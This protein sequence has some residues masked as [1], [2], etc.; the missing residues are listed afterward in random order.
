MQRMMQ[1]IVLQ[2]DNPAAGGK[3]GSSKKPAKGSTIIKVEDQ[4]L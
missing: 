2:L 3:A 4:D 1:E